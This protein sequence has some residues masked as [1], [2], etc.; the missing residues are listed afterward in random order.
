MQCCANQ[1]LQTHLQDQ[2]DPSWHKHPLMT[3]L[4]KR[5]K[6]YPEEGDKQHE[7]SNYP[8]IKIWGRLMEH[9]DQ[10]SEACFQLQ[11]LNLTVNS[12]PLLPAGMCVAGRHPITTRKVMS[13]AWLRLAL[14]TKTLVVCACGIASMLTDLLSPGL[15]R[16]SPW[17]D[18]LKQCLTYLIDQTWLPWCQ[19]LHS[20]I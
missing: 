15:Y 7:V 12:L 17:I 20:N 16:W 14:T 11:D 4:K 3:N 6:N 9:L 8:Q 2:A 18:L 13:G 10:R 19:I 1:R 5:V